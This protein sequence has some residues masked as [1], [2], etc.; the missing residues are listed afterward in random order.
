MRTC[1]KAR[2]RAFLCTCPCLN[3]CLICV[4]VC[5]HSPPS[6]CLRVHQLCSCYAKCSFSRK[7]LCYMCLEYTCIHIARTCRWQNSSRGSVFLL[8]TISCLCSLHVLTGKYVW[9]Y[10]LHFPLPAREARRHRS[11][12]TLADCVCP[13]GETDNSQASYSSSSGKY[14]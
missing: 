13:D 2:A 3:W 14:P 9:V 7:R 11:I 5:F 4:C 6:Q 8:R 1:S 12:S 10:R